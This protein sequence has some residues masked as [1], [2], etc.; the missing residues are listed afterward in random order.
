MPSQP[1]TYVPDFP[2][3]PVAPSPRRTADVAVAIA[4]LVVC[5]FVGVVAGGF[6]LMSLAFSD[7]CRAPDCDVDVFTTTIYLTL[8]SAL[9]V[10]TV[11]GVLTLVRLGQ[12]RT[13]APYAVATLVLVTATFVVGMVVWFQS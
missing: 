8:A 11:G 5:G 6:G 13:A 12:R 4:A 1:M 7:G 9:L 3:A 2:V 10:G